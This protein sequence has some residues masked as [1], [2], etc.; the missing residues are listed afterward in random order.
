MNPE[1]KFL[2]KVVRNSFILAGLY[3]VS[4]WA[5]GDLTYQLFKPILIF[6]IT[7]ILVELAKHYKIHPTSKKATTST[8]IFS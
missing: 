6:F 8:M 7:Y 1:V 4:V 2:L 3:F 5:T